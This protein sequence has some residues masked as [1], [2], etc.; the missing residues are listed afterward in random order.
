MS[1]TTYNNEVPK[2]LFYYQTFTSLK[3]I[4]EMNPC[5]VTHIHLASIHFG[6]DTDGNPY[7][8]LNNDSPYNCKFNDVWDE[9][10]EASVKGIKIKLMIGGAGGA[11]YSLFSNFEIFY[12][13]LADVL[14]L[15][16]FITGIDLDIE[17]ECD[18]NDVKCL[19]DRL[20]IDFGN[21]ISISMAPI[22]SSLESDTPGM[23]GFSY[24]DLIESP[25]GKNIDYFNVQFYSDYS[26][27]AFDR[28]VKNGYLPE[29]IVMGALAGEKD[30]NELEKCVK[31]YGKRF[32][33][34]FVWEY[35]FA[36]PTPVD[37]AEDVGKI[38][39]KGNKETS[40]FD[41]ITSWFNWTVN[42]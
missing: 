2:V 35:C 10:E 20:K 32:G 12:S 41:Y 9:L 17:E 23:G 30:D 39:K 24:K 1:T 34:V 22:Q 38:C 31:K 11:Y 16:P 13:M 42:R 25:E 26:C 37:W 14:Q 15:K 40:F 5:P 21:R 28:I 36:K 29:M 3:P 8:H 7:I 27:D 18:M 33:G 6:L 19:I 4:L